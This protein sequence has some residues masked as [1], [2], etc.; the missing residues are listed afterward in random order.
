[1][2]GIEGSLPLIF[3]LDVYIV[4]ALV[5]IQLGKVFGSVE[6][7][8]EFRDKGQEVLVLHHYGVKSPVVLH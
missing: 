8:H 2:V 4:K 6:L 3:R 1:M 5:D 7:Q